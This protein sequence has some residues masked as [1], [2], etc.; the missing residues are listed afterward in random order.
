MDGFQAESIFHGFLLDYEDY[1][2][3]LLTF[4]YDSDCLMAMWN[5]Y[6]QKDCKR[7]LASLVEFFWI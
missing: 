3:I 4:I 5:Q 6:Q 7:R 1:T 2:E